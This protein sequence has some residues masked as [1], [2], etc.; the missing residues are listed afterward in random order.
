MELEIQNLVL[1][2]GGQI[3]LSGLDI[4]ASGGQVVLLSGPNGSGKSTLL[5]AVAGLSAPLA[6]TI[7][8]GPPT[9][10]GQTSD[11]GLADDTGPAHD[12]TVSHDVGTDRDA[13]CH[14][15]G[16]ANALRPEQTVG[17]SAAFFAQYFA[18]A[19]GLSAVPAA[20]MH[21]GVETALDTL[22]L[23]DLQDVPVGLLSSGQTRR[24]ALTRLLVAWRP[25]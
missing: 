13:L 4:D 7:A 11:T 24:T 3:V 17:E 2:R 15:I 6:G 22:G 10:N 19:G 9:D 25:V 23:T 1:A 16:H 8:M 5:R 18:A 21:L 14:Y 20:A 12:T